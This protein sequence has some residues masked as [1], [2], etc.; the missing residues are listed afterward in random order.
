M[1]KIVKFTLLSLLSL[2]LM[3]YIVYAMFFLSVPD[4]EERC[5]AVELAVKKDNGASAFVDAGDIEKM[6]KNAN[7][8]PKGML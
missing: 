1:S 6:L 5:V 3:A 2:G 7:V 8:Y 4:D